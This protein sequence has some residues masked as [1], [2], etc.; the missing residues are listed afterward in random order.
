MSL[1]SVSSLNNQL[2]A[3]PPTLSSHEGAT[4]FVNVIADYINQ[5]QAG[6]TGSPGI[7]TYTRPP[8]IAAIEALPPVIDNSWIPNFAAAVHLGVTSG[9]LTPGTVTDPAW[10]ASVVDVLPPVIITLP[11]ALA[12][13]TA[14]LAPVTSGNN[15]AM[16][17][18]QA[19]HDYALA[20]TFLCTG[21]ALAL[22]AP[23]IPVPL[24]FPAQ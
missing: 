21:L 4:Q 23:P 22:P 6:P 5:V 2:L 14:G 10:T 19:I 16:P 24:P 8:A 1:P 11:A 12:V 18:A 15:P 13:L 7:L 17:M 3:L 9:I 20:F